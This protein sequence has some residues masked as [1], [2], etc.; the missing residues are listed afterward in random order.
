[1]LAG[2]VCV[3]AVG[4][5]FGRESKPAPAKT[6]IDYFLPM[7]ITD[8]LSKEA[9]GAPE[10]GARDTKNGL[11]DPTMKHW[12]Y[13][14]GQIIKAPD[15]KY[16]MFASRWDQAGGHRDWVNSKAVHAV[17]DNLT[18]PYVDKGL[19]WPDMTRR[20]TSCATATAR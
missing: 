11:E 14:D 19:C 15:G 17:S 2:L 13:W 6:F 3:F 10:V 20:K 7:P 8:S 16:H 12:C 4:T 1:M 5:G 18:G 9:W